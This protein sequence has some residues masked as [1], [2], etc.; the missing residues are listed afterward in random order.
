MVEDQQHW[1]IVVAKASPMSLRQVSTMLRGSGDR[2]YFKPYALG[3][4][5]SAIIVVW[6]K[7]KSEVRMEVVAGFF[8]SSQQTTT[9]D[10]TCSV[11]EFTSSTGSI[12]VFPHVNSLDS[13]NKFGV[14][15][16]VY[17]EITSFSRDDMYQWNCTSSDPVWLM[18]N[19]FKTRDNEQ[20]TCIHLNTH[21]NR[22][23]W[24]STNYEPVWHVPTGSEMVPCFAGMT[25]T[26][27]DTTPKT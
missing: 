24:S 16:H 10:F 25:M 20:N 5:S 22:Y 12:H 4:L 26:T 27:L 1:C 7:N 17:R 2:R 14:S 13:V 8:S 18:S 21:E 11:S 19:S 23:W 3:V 6:W 15:T 9:R